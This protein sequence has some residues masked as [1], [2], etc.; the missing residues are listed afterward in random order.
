MAESGN[1]AINEVKTG[2]VSRMNNGLFGIWLQCPLAS[3]IKISKPGKLKIGWT[4][5]KV[6]FLKARPMQCFRCWEIGHL[7]SQCTNNVDR[8][9]LCYR[10][11][12]PGHVARQCASELCC[13][14]CLQ[15]GRNACH[16]VGSGLCKAEKLNRGPARR[17]GEQM[18]VDAPLPPM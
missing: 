4:I 10:C 15:Q 18:D 8:T 13:A 17:T 9:G 3:A 12:Q 7:K 16:R 6:E 1:C 14:L 2:Q 5:A 11:G